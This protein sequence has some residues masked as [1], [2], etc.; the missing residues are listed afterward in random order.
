MSIDDKDSY[1]DVLEFENINVKD[2]L[3]TILRTNGNETNVVI[4]RNINFIVIDK[5]RLLSYNEIKQ[6][7]FRNDTE[8]DYDVK[9][10]D[11]NLY[12]PCLN[13]EGYIGKHRDKEKDYRCINIPF[14]NLRDFGLD[15]ML[16]FNDINNEFMNHKYFVVVK[17]NINITGF[18]SSTVLNSKG[19]DIIEGVNQDFVN[20]L[21]CQS[22]QETTYVYRLFPIKDSKINEIISKEI[23]SEEPPLKRQRKA[24]GKRKK[25]S[26]KTCKRK[27]SIKK[28]IKKKSIKKKSIKKKSIKNLNL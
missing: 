7:D 3:R 4:K 24:D 8:P 16:Y 1:Y 12:Y 25:K 22:G 28:K 20:A 14:V 6:N 21:H 10:L 15:G 5:Q 27:S 17:I 19:D 26:K 9:R 11:K 23:I 2:F 13:N 18:V